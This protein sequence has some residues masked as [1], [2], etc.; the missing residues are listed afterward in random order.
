MTFKEDYFEA[1]IKKNFFTIKNPEKDFINYV[2]AFICAHIDT[3]SIEDLEYYVM[4]LGEDFESLLKQRYFKS[5]KIDRYAITGFRN[6]FKSWAKDLIETNL[7]N[8]AEFGFLTTEP[9][10]K[11]FTEKKALKPY[12]VSDEDYQKACGKYFGEL[13]KEYG[14]LSGGVESAQENRTKI[15]NMLNEWQQHDCGKPTNENI[16][17]ATGLSI[18]TIKRHTKNNDV[19]EAKKRASEVFKL[20]NNKVTEKPSDESINAEEKPS[21]PWEQTATTSE[22]TEEELSYFEAEHLGFNDFTDE[23]LISH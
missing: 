5:S 19:K 6:H 3:L 4:C 20:V 21:M 11:Y 10:N 13:G 14:K 9:D 18:I 23:H 15:I 12:N 17:K 7:D 22:E 2:E 16:A 8:L 1:V